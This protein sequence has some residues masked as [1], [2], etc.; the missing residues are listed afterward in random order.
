MKK[1][2][3]KI[4]VS[5][6]ILTFLAT[7]TAFITPKAVSAAPV[8]PVRGMVTINGVVADGATVTL[9]DNNN[10]ASLTD[11]VGTSGA[12]ATSGNYLFD[13]AILSTAAVN[14]DSID[15]S[16]AVSGVTGSTQFT[17]DS[18]AGSVSLPTIDLV[19]NT[20][21]FGQV[22]L[23]GSPANGAAVTL[24]DTTNN[25]SLTDTVGVN[26][27]SGLPGWYSFDLST[28]SPAG[29]DGDAVSIAATT[30][31]GFTGSASFTYNSAGLYANM[32]IDIIAPV[33][34][35]D[36]ATA[37][38]SNSATINGTIVSDGNSPIAFSGFYWG[39]ST[40][41]TNMATVF[42]NTLP[43]NTGGGSSTGP[44]SFD[45]TG[46]LPNTTY[47]YQA[48]ASN[49]N[50]AGTASG[51]DQMFTTSSTVPT[52]TIPVITI[53][54][55]STLPGGVV[56]VAYSQNILATSTNPNDVLTWSISSGSLP[57]GLSMSTSTGLISGTPTTT[58][59]S[60]FS[61]TVTGS[62]VSSTPAV[63]SFTLVVTNPVVIVGLPV[64]TTN[65]A[66]NITTSTVTLNGNLTS[67]GNLPI[68]ASGFNYGTT[69]AYGHVVTSTISG[70]STGAFSSDLI[71]L[72]ANTGYHYRAYATNASGTATGIDQVF[73]TAIHSTTST[74]TTTIDKDFHGTTTIDID[75]DVTDPK[76]DFHELVVTSTTSTSATLVGGLDSWGD[77]V[78]LM[79]P[80]GTKITGTT[81]WDGLIH[82]PRVST[83]SL[84]A[85]A[86]SGFNDSV[87]DVINVSGNVPLSFDHPVKLMIPNQPAGRHAF[88]NDGSSHDIAACT[89]ANNTLGNGQNECYFQDGTNMVIWT[90]HFTK[91]GT[92]TQAAINNGGGSSGNVTSGGGGGG[93]AF[94]SQPY[95][96]AI[97]LVLMIN[98]GAAT[99]N[100]QNVT[101][102]LD[103]GS[104]AR[105][106][107]I[108][109]TAD[110]TNAPQQTYY[111]T[112]SWVLTPG[113][114]MKTVY[115][116]FFNSYGSPSA[117]VSA[118]IG[119]ESGSPSTVV[120]PP[121]GQV[122]GTQIY[123]NGLLLRTPDGHIY[124]IVN[125]GKKLVINIADLKANYKGKRIVQINDDLSTFPDYKPYSNGVLLRGIDQRIYYIQNGQKLYIPT[126]EQL[127]T[128]RG[129][130][131]YQVTDYVLSV[132]PDV[133][134]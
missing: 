33:V 120:T 21:V 18:T 134:M 20:V 106:M 52:S 104:D 36:P 44:F 9:T 66:T 103:G 99:T 45:L 126:L 48:I 115:A 81:T 46:L 119:L 132:Y 133:S 15:V 30:T 1:L 94:I 118:S 57:A 59:T 101:L 11:T 56:G 111:T 38:T 128:Y 76:A 105:S 97:S 90:T 58:A 4:K 70:T 39:T 71:S 64:L 35:T 85:P 127:E 40:V 84:D 41:Y 54:T 109:N 87:N 50:A 23:N 121:S 116:K 113:D 91:F 89:G 110:F 51:A 53:N 60:T 6:L 100:N 29:S 117:V 17:Y 19:S 47:H 131:M 25:A 86:V 34:T 3:N 129:K 72:L 80:A 122:L 93:V 78:E 114:G 10:S 31:D 68:T 62:D 83:S 28:L 12:S 88:Y 63:S 14:G 7:Q 95:N 108:S 22:T 67:T 69:T 124:Y 42:D 61:V 79:I 82:L 32:S 98:G 26:G 24:T 5:F 77:G 125:G 75:H 130:K 74:A 112:G 27:N 2:K 65:S 8:Y 55:S 43:V 92:Y 107:A 16:V 37:I 13:L 49:V 123:K 73:Q 96:S 102:T